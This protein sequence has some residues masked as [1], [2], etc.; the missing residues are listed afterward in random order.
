MSRLLL[1]CIVVLLACV[2]GRT[3][4]ADLL[5]PQHP[6]PLTPTPS[7][8]LLAASPYYI[9]TDIQPGQL[10]YFNFTRPEGVREFWLSALL[11]PAPLSPSPVYGC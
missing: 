11:H 2:D 4:L 8:D 3:P 5:R 6:S 1:L 10:N 9:P 7:P